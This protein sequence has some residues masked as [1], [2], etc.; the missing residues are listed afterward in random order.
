MIRGLYTSAM[1]M[2]TQMA[3]LDVVANNLANANTNGFRGGTAVNS[4]FPE[5]LM[6]RM[7]AVPGKPTQQ[8]IPV[9]GVGHGVTIANI[10]TNF[11]QGPLERTAGDLDLAIGGAGFFAVE[12]NIAGTPTEMFTRNGAFTLNAERTLVNHNGDRVLN[13]SGNHITVPDGII[14][15]NHAGEIQVNGQLVDTIRIVNFEDP[16]LLRQFGYT[17]FSQNDAVEIP[18]EGSIEQG[19]LER[20][21]VNVVREMVHMIK[22]SR[23]YELNQRMVSIQDIT[24][25]QAVND[26]AR[27]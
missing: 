1:G 3:N 17:L 26:I 7:H 20:S 8:V 4:S 6:S 2:A 27:R 9:G 21:N 12:S 19:Y 11:K 22:I 23:A 13:T 16:T 25:Q 15:I 10:H 24:L 18:F 14:E 5:V